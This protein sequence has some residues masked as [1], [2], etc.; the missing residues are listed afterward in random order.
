MGQHCLGACKRQ[1]YDTDIRIPFFIRGPGVPEGLV[2][3]QPVCT[4]APRRPLKGFARVGGA[5]V[6]VCVRV[7]LA[8]PH[9][10]P[11]VRSVGAGADKHAST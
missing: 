5:C 1:P 4:Q 7:C 9:A 10:D 8:V 11:P 6:R 3:Q 2:L